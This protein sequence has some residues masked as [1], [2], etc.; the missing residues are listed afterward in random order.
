MR[1]SLISDVRIITCNNTIRLAWLPK[2]PVGGSRELGIGGQP[3]ASRRLRSS[4][5]EQ[6]ALRAV[7]FNKQ[8]NASAESQKR[9]LKRKNL[10]ETIVCSHTSWFRYRGRSPL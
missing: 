6:P 7:R 8:T 5:D 3:C 9:F 10:G 4:W 2:V 1:Q